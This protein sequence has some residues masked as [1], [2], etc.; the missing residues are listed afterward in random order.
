MSRS[1]LALEFGT[2]VGVGA[3][4]S[5][6]GDP[7]TLVKAIVKARPLPLVVAFALILATNI[8]FA[9]ALAG[10]IKRRLP[11]WPNVKLQ[12]AGVFSN[13]ALP[14]GS[15]A[16]QVRFLQKQGVDAATAVA[17][18]GIINLAA[19]TLTQIGLF[20][21]ALELSPREVDVGQ[22]PTGAVTTVLII[23]VVAIL[24][25]SLVVLAIPKLRTRVV[26]PVSRGV[27][28]ILDVLR[29]PRQIA[30]LIGGS[31]LAYVLYGLAL[32]ATLRALGE[33]PSIWE[34]IAANLGVTL[35]AA[36]V[37]F[38][39]GGTA[40]SSVGLSG[41]LVAIGVPETAAVGGVLIHQVLSQYVPALP[42]WLALRSLI[43]HEEL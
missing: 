36:L 26:P 20:F 4:L 25:A 10:S 30:L 33:S 37:P 1:N 29:S 35:V 21:L 12:I 40:V 13:L 39:G 2:L 5:A 23:A 41:A 6:V 31:A 27:K 11:F 32:A 19:G 16:L 7:N 38:P 3:L 17:A 34:L 14:F 22:I 18:G 15:Q 28:T 43:A 24:V 8:G 42:G 9:L